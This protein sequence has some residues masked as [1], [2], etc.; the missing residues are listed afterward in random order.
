MSSCPNTDIDP[1]ILMFSFLNSESGADVQFNPRLDRLIERAKSISMPKQSVE[2]AIKTGAG[3]RLY[4]FLFLL[5]VDLFN[6]LRNF[7]LSDCMPDCMP[8]QVWRA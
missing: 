2:N 3:V 5:D 4:D 8:V 1:Q 6:C 7:S